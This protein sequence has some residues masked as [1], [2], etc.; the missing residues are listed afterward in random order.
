MPAKPTPPKASL[1]R[2]VWR[3]P[4]I[5]ALAWVG[6][7]CCSWGLHGATGENAGLQ[8]MKLAGGGI[9]LV[10]YFGAVL[11]AAVSLETVIRRVWGSADVYYDPR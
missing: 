2:V 8:W 10:S 4:L 9:G 5:A 3:V 1:M 11:L 7:V 6:H